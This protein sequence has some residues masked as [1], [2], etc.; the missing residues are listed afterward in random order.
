MSKT[1]KIPAKKSASTAKPR[2]SIGLAR[3][4]RG[5]LITIYVTADGVPMP[6]EKNRVNGNRIL[7]H[8]VI[9]GTKY[10]Q[11]RQ[12]LLKDSGLKDELVE[13]SANGKAVAKKAKA[14]RRTK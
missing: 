6:Y 5:K 12:K 1:K 9:T 7:F 10:S 14:E 4:A 11:A 3:N 2:W 13:G 8:E